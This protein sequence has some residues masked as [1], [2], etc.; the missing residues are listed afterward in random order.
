MICRCFNK[1]LDL[2]AARRAALQLL[3]VP[4]YDAYLAHLRS[5]HPDREPPTRSEFH[6]VRAAAKSVQLRCC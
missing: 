2:S 1:T 4:D 6:R 5:T 3:G